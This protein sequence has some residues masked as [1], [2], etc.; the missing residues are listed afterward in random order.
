MSEARRGVVVVWN[1]MGRSLYAWDGL[2]EW[3]GDGEE[4]GR[5]TSTLPLPVSLTC[6]ANESSRPDA[7]SVRVRKAWCGRLAVLPSRAVRRILRVS[8]VP[9]VTGLL[10]GVEGVS[11]GEKLV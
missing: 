10:S 8:V 11:L 9:R 3:V 2:L 4:E 7:G 1:W 5:T 6:S